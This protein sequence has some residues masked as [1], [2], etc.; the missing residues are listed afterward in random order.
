VGREAARGGLPV[1]LFGTTAGVL[2]AASRELDRRCGDGLS[3][4]GAQ[5][6]APG[7]DPEGAEAEAAIEEIAASGARLC[8][9]A[10]GA[11]KQ[12]LFAARA[13]AKGVKC[14]FV[15]IGAAL[16]FLA[17]RQR[18]APRAMQKL[19]L[20]WL[21]RL[22]TNPRRLAWRY[23]QCALVLADIAL[24]RPLHARLPGFRKRPAAP[25]G[26]PTQSGVRE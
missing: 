9:V 11:P 22:A 12:E 2:E 16:D 7:F 17:G 6:P 1:Y 8:F 24:A 23:A 5:S 20:E 19:N 25:G 14:G 21:W 26:S 3:I 15:C 10:L 18:R 4:A 13:K